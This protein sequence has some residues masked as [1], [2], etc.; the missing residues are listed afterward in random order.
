MTSSAPRTQSTGGLGSTPDRSAILKWVGAMVLSTPWS[1]G[2]KPGQAS[3][4]R[5]SPGYQYSPVRVD[6]IDSTKMSRCSGT[7]GGLT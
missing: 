4:G 2:A 5:E 3:T 1:P 7:C 6:S